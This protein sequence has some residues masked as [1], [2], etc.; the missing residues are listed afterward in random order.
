MGCVD[1]SILLVLLQ[2]LL[3]LDVRGIVPPKFISMYSFDDD[4]DDDDED[5][6]FR[7]MVTRP[8]L[9]LFILF[10][11]LFDVRLFHDIFM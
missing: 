4:I 9:L 8:A 1:I 2:S 5:C 6:R 10:A 3:A 11:L 7:S